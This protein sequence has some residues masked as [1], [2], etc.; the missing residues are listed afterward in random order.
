MSPALPHS[1][2]STDGATGPGSESVAGT[3][4]LIVGASSTARA[5]HENLTTAWRR[6]SVRRVDTYLMALGE[7]V[8]ETPALLIGHVADVDRATAATLN[9]LRRLAP[10]T[11]LLLLASPDREADARR[12]VAAG[13]DQYLLEP[14][15]ATA[16]AHML[17]EPPLAESERSGQAVEQQ[18]PV[19]A[20]V[21]AAEPASDRK[22]TDVDL[23]EHLLQQEQGV[24]EVAL[25]IMS[26]RTGFSPA[27]W[28]A[29]AD[30]VPAGRVCLPVVYA[31]QA[32]GYLHV[33]GGTPAD[34]LAPWAEWLGRWLALE[35][36]LAELKSAALTDELTGLWNRRYFDQQLLELLTRAADERFRVTLM[37]FDIDDFKLYNDRYG[38]AAGDE[39]LR[40]CGKLMR[41]EVRNHDVV[42]RIGGDEFGVIFWDADQPRR[43]NSRHPVD[44]RLAA[45]RFQQAVADHRFPKLGG[46]APGTLTIS[47]GLAGFPWDGRT[48][49]DLFERADA[50]AQHSKNNGKNILTFGPGAVR[51]DSADPD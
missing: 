43:P 31:G 39:I 30:Q 41:A 51:G 38:H 13:F 40:E 25:E 24:T 47:A 48:P 6:A 16:L 45:E 11:R 27:A 50:M 2:A 44:V 1:A 19:A 28:C 12:A 5:L 29:A 37:I 26:Q 22:L 23:F 8:A 42:A 20:P 49:E 17:V 3:H 4:V 15:D 34:G 14:L 9:A 46:S 18:A 10:Q 32:L 21:A 36:R 33:P 7:V 35:H